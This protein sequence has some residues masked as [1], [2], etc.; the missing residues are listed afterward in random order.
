MAP[1]RRR[2]RPPDAMVVGL[3]DQRRRRSARGRGGQPSLAPGVHRRL[4]VAASSAPT[5]FGWRLL[6]HPTRSTTSRSTTSRPTSGCRRLSGSATAT[7]PTPPLLSPNG[8]SVG[9][10]TS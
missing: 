10:P 6:V 2:G 9:P 5:D 3:D 7:R 8:T 4:H 1:D